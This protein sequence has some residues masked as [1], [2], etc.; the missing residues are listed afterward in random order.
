[1]EPRSSDEGKKPMNPIILLWSNSF[2]LIGIREFP[3]TVNVSAEF[4]G[5]CIGRRSFAR[6]DLEVSP[7]SVFSFEFDRA[8]YPEFAKDF[9]EGL[10]LGI[11]DGLMIHQFHSP[12][13]RTAI[14]VKSIRFDEVTSTNWAFRMAGRIAVK[15]AF[16]IVESKVHKRLSS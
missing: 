13:L 10:V 12:F 8:G 16:E 3:G 1:M 14:K 5:P 11:L 2:S 6:V 9:E 4:N 7:A 15:Q